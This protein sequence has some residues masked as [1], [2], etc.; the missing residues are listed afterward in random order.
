MVTTQK[1][2][3]S[4]GQGFENDAQFPM[5]KNK[6]LSKERNNHYVNMYN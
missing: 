6:A 4:C 2:K 3:I 1:S 5:Q